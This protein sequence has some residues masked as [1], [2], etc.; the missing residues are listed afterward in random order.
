[1][2]RFFVVFA[3]RRSC[4]H[5]IMNWICKNTRESTLHI[6]E[7]E[8]T[9][10]GAVVSHPKKAE[11]YNKKGDY[12]RNF[13]LTDKSSIKNFVYNFENFDLRDYKEN[14]FKN[15][16]EFQDAFFKKILIIRDGLNTFASISKRI[17]NELKHKNANL[18]ADCRDFDKIIYLWK[19][20]AEQALNKKT[21]IKD[22]YVINTN[23]W[24]ASKEYRMKICADLRLY[25]SDDGINEVSFYGGLSSFDGGKFDQK[26]SEMKILERYKTIDKKYI[27]KLKPL[28]PLS[29]ELF[30]INY[31]NI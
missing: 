26:A 11:F 30:K 23:E 29:K 10:L 4:H 20:Y 14:E 9:E 1:M 27:E 12:K 16:F 22:L 13:I 7:P 15:L 2:K 21:I 5:A 3:T 18:I 17:E 6:N 19:Q 24:F 25:F 28:I 31:E 8:I